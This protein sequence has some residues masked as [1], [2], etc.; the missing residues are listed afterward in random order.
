[1]RELNATSIA[2]REEQC[3]DICKGLMTLPILLPPVCLHKL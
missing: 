2:M 1:M 3:S